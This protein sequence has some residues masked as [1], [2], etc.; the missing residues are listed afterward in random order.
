MKKR[1]V[2]TFITAMTFGLTS[3][4]F[5][6]SYVVAEDNTA[7]S[8]V[9]EEH[10]GIYFTDKAN[11]WIRVETGINCGITLGGYNDNKFY[12]PGESPVKF[13]VDDESIA[14]ITKVQGCL[15]NVKGVSAGE[16]T[17]HAETPDGQTASVKLVSYVT[18]VTTTTAVWTTPNT[19]T[20][21]IDGI[22]F[23]SSSIRIENGINGGISLQGYNDGKFYEVGESPIEFTIDDEQIA[24]I[25]QVQGI[26]VN[27]MGIAEGET[28]LHAKTPDGKTASVKLI[29]PKAVVTTTTAVWTNNS[30]TTT[31][32]SQ[33]EELSFGSPSIRIELDIN[34]GISLQGYND[35]KF[36]EPGES[37]V[38]Y[39]IDDESI[40]KITKVQGY[41]VNVM[42]VSTGET[43][44][45]AQTPDGR[46]ASV[47][48]IVP[49]RLINTTTTAHVINT[50]ATTTQTVTSSVIYDFMPTVEIDKSPMVVGETREG[51]FYNPETKK[52]ENGSVYSASDAIS[53]DYTKGSD[54][55]KITALKAGEASISFNAK[56][57]AFSGYVSLKV[58]DD[59]IKGDAN[60]DGTVDMSDVV[61]IM[62]A[63]ANP[64]KYGENGTAEVH[65][66]AQGKANADMDGNGLTVGDAQKI[67][68][69]LLGFE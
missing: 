31:T 53:I 5:T 8:A 2:L 29:V 28:I 38:K 6:S 15:V 62:Q 17:L 45:H 40:A 50:T 12:E 59:K 63:L 41:L 23:G 42:G 68:M 3:M 64:N 26:L 20:T 47:K 60:G 58:I 48:L 30:T 13:T 46:T 32:V 4:F 7:V 25:T 65:L 51:R 14:K 16:T 18:P 1:K 21:R 56:G 36:Y 33:T 34:G 37:P 44:L 55:F 19:T 24:K 52:N 9:T 11:D 27:V 67:Q 43:T 54:T 10:N 39:T 22:T 69:K 49:D 61:L 57:C 35:S 66:T